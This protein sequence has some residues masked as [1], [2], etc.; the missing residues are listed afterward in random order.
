MRKTKRLLS[1]LL[2]LIMALSLAACGGSDNSATTDSAAADS[3]AASEPAETSE[4]SDTN[5]A[6]A[7]GQVY[8][9]NFKPEQEEAYLEI[10][11]AYTEATGVTVKVVT[12]ASGTYETQLRSEMAKREAPTIFQINGPVGYANWSSY[13]LDL[14]DTE[15]YGHLTDESLAVTGEDGGVY[16]IPFA[17]EGY[18]IIYNLSIMEKYFATDGAVVTGIDEINNFETLK[19]VAEDMTDKKDELGIEGVFACT[20]LA[21]GEEWRWQTHLA[22]VPLYYEFQA[23]KLD[24]SDPDATSE[25]TFQY[26]DNFKN[27]FDLYLDYSTTEKGLLGSKT[28]NDSM[29]EFALGKCAMVQNGNWAYGQISAE[30]GNVVAEEDVGFLPLYTGMEGEEKQG[31]CIGTE[32]FFCINSEA[33]AEDQQ[34]SLDFLTWLYT[35]DEGKGY[36]TNDLGFIAPFDTFS[37]ADKP[38]D[39]LGKLVMEW[40]ADSSVTNV[41]WNFTVFPSQYF[42][43]LFGQNLLQYAQGSMSWDDVVSNT[44][45]DWASEK[46]NAAAQ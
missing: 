19:A 25:I 6:S 21:T 5:S 22:N 12:A 26:S 2:A 43:D 28:V 17:I 29:A 16:G 44:I 20:S 30:S 23:N 36:V 10:A 18:G 4:A 15:L 41:P 32:N 7:S 14:S 35:S 31:I 40:S 8:F 33:S 46:A 13:C 37:D 38:A 11:A 24:L 3:A 42:K 27:L 45:S 1:V 34:A 39:P 9:L